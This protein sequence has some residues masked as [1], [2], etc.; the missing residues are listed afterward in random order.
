MLSKALNTPLH[1]TLLN[2][3]TSN[4]EALDIK[5]QIKNSIASLKLLKCKRYNKYYK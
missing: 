3:P 5:N 4:F 1:I 2:Q